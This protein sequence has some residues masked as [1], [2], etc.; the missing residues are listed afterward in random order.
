MSPES[1]SWEVR[2]SAEE[3]YIID[4]QTYDQVASA[5]GVSIS[6]L[7]R[8]GMDSAPSWTER[9]KEYRQAQSSV[10]R[11]V[12]LAKAK[13][14]ESV[15]D[16]QDPM[17]A[18]AFNS[19]VKSGQAIDDDARE[20][21]QQSTAKAEPAKGEIVTDLP[22]AL[23]EAIQRKIGL[24]L[25]APGGVTVNSIKDLQQSMTLLEKLKAKIAEESGENNRSQGTSSET[26]DQLRAAIMKELGA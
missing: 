8:W 19:L 10:R 9:R 3:L 2:E 14:I 13:L 11:N 6:Q 21:N 24:M 15:L 1:Y 23:S 12:M 16:S 22:A 20:R 17:K 26:I 5:T 7:K 18:F 25:S 4:G